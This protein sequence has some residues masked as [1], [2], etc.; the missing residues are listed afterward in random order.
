[1]NNSKKGTSMQKYNVQRHSAAVELDK[2]LKLLAEQ[3][4]SED[5][6]EQALA[7]EP[8][9]STDEVRRRLQET[10]DAFVLMAK[11][12]SPSF[13]GLKNVANPLRRAQAGGVLNL[14]D[15]LRIAGVLRTMR[16]ISDWRRK[17]EGMKTTLD[18]RFESVVPNKYLE[19]K[20]NAVVI[21]EEEVAD[22]AS[23][24]LASIRRRIR[25]ASS[26]VRE[27]LD[28]MIRSAAYQKYLQDPIV[29]MR[30]GRYVVPVKAECRG[31][32][33][34]LVHDT[35]SSGA[36]VFVEPMGVVEANNEIRVLQ[37]RES[38]E[39]ERI[40]AELSAEAGGFA[41]LIIESY[42]AAVGLD[43]IFA[44]GQLAYKMKA[45]MPKVND[46]GRILLN[47]AR[48]P[49]IDPKQVV[50]MNIELGTTFDTLVITGPNTGG[51]TVTLKTLGLLTL[52]AMCGLM[53]PVGDNSEI[54]VFHQ[55]LADIGDE[56][57]IEQSLS[58]FSAHMTN[59]IQIIEQADERSLI[60]LDELGAGTD[61]VEGAA[62]AMAIL[63]ALR[64][65]HARVAATTH[66]AE[67]KAY[68]LQTA[69]VENGS[70][71]FDVATLR[72]TYRL[73]IGV[74]GRSNAFAISSRLGLNQ[75]IVDR[76]RELVSGE[77]RR[78]EDVVQNLEQSRQKLEA[79]RRQAQEQNAEARR[80]SEEAREY[81]ER[82]EREA[83][84]EIEQ[85]RERAAQL[86]ARTRAQ[87]DALLEELEEMKRQGAKSMTAEQRARMKAGMR[88]MESASDPVSRKEPETY[89]LPRPLKAG[90]DVLIFDI[91]KE[92][93]VVETP[94]PDD[95][96]VLVQAG[97]I[98][99]RVPVENLRLLEQKTQNRK[100]RRSGTRNVPKR[101]DA[102]VMTEVDV[103]G[104]DSIEAVM[105]VD[106]AIDSA[107]LSGIHQ[108]TIIHGKGTGV[109]R[110][111][112]QQH[113]RRHPSVRTYRLGV[114]GEGESGVTI[115]E[116]K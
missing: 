55:V 22:N 88:D 43:L 18:W 41:D 2:I 97:I 115:V 24:E 105:S 89:V 8:A 71:E 16:A 62:L 6:S 68:A 58:T 85:A 12:G 5:A 95:K 81:R 116:L 113:L 98:K 38:A 9:V 25:A 77:D 21:S 57:S 59:I 7:L 83:A 20:I 14:V 23:P 103:R 49:L 35:S 111:A 76:A 53:L 72:P 107:L 92:G 63:E 51:K 13:S 102:P 104:E 3:T 17:S 60:L 36:T 42:H 79:E 93:T 110:T 19:E 96:K 37:S 27:Q 94:A 26:R 11:F 47:Q 46:T 114:F 65:R 91:D 48:H 75:E 67:L 87:A 32:I 108:L 40:L 45:S 73:L 99:T 39:I 10:D 28:K 30:G 34:G 50:P 69:G 31:E 82:L 84:K 100:A 80:I 112:V 64:E 54:S 101:S 29:T 52:M 61:P 90:D 86:V 66:Y 4:A 15:F 70:C 106:R 78:F 1:M 74:P 33:P 56:Q 44:K 109:L